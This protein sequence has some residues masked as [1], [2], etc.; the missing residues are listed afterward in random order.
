[1][2]SFSLLLKLFPSPVSLST[3]KSCKMKHIALLHSFKELFTILYLT[4]IFFCLLRIILHQ[5]RALSLQGILCPAVLM[6]DVEIT[7]ICTAEVPDILSSPLL[8]LLL[9]T[10][11]NIRGVDCTDK[12]MKDLHIYSKEF[13]M[14]TAD[15]LQVNKET[16][17]VGM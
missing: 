13:G 3:T 15:N 14:A 5:G 12:A 16:L 10:T 4:V 1:M 7:G 17:G 8:P 6:R 11:I 2:L 9:I